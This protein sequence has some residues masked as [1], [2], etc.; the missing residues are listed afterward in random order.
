[1]GSGVELDGG[2][3]SLGCQALRELRTEPL[4]D[5]VELVDER[6]LV[7]L[8]QHRLLLDP[9]R[10]RLGIGTPFGPFRSSVVSRHRTLRDR[11]SL[12]VNRM[13]VPFPD[14]GEGISDPFFGAD[15]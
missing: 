1:V 12:D 7:R 9:D 10:E 6:E 15:A 3:V 8:E 14:S 13:A 5:A 11:P 2:P 4:A